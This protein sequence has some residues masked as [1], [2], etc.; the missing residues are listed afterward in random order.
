[1]SKFGDV[2]RAQEA[3]RALMTAEL[4]DVRNVELVADVLRVCGYTVM[5]T[6]VADG[7]TAKLLAYERE[8]PDRQPWPFD[9]GSIVYPKINS[10]ELTVLGYKTHCSYWANGEYR[11][12][13]F[14]PDELHAPA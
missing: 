2:H 8:Q 14:S 11:A 13:D 1:M 5:P 6:E 3:L 10:I 9:I 12:A 7:Q 4:V